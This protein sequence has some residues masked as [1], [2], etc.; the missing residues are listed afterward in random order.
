MPTLQIADKATLDN[1]ETKVE[2]VLTDI[3][4]T[5]ATGGTTTAGTVMGKLNAILSG[6]SNIGGGGSDNSAD[7]TAIKTATATNNTAST[8]GT[9]SQKLSS[10]IANTATNNTENKTGILSQKLSYLINRANKVVT[11]SNTNLK[12]LSSSGTVTVPYVNQMY[13]GAAKTVSSNWTGYGYVQVP[14]IYRFSTT[15]SVA[16][17]QDGGDGTNT[18]TLEVQVVSC[19]TGSTYSKTITIFSSSAAVSSTTKTLDIPLGVGDMVR[20][21]IT[22][23]NGP[24]AIECGGSAYGDG[25]TLTWTDISVR[26]TLTEIT[27]NAVR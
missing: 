13:S 19:N 7:I 5:N 16:I 8:T 22:C 11:P 4:P 2:N 1:V 3:G 20:C 10:A 17:T 21:R 6:L 23:K 9:L 27:T 14:G 25:F 12:Q 18:G 26:G 15:F 24:Y